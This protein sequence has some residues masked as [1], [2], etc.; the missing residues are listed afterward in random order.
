MIVW[1]FLIALVGALREAPLQKC[2]YYLLQIIKEMVLVQFFWND[3][4]S[5]LQRPENP[6][7]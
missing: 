2:L 4:K 3:T 1:N 6:P 7:G 5:A